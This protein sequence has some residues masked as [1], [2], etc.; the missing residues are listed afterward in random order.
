MASPPIKEIK[1]GDRNRYRFT[2]DIGVD[3]RTGKRRQI[4]RTFDGKRQAERELA[5]VLA[6]VATTRTPCRA[7]SPS[8]ST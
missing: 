2:V 4:K 8:S 3:P 5:K 7:G 6:A 1:V